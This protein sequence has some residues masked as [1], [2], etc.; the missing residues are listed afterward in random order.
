MENGRKLVVGVSVYLVAK[1]VLN[2]IL[3]FGGSNIF[4]LILALVYA[5]VLILGI[6]Y[7]NYVVA[8]IVGLTVIWHFK[9]N[10]TN[11]P[12]NLIYLIEGII[13]IGAVALLVLAKD[14]KAFF[15]E[16]V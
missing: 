14:V 9:D 2:L 12:A 11:L 16:D 15:G 3:S 1:A 10:V 13:D 7:A 8:V 6:K 4:G 5:A